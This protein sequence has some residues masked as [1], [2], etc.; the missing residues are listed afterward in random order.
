MSL[1]DA[2]S[3][4][5]ISSGVRAGVSHARTAVSVTVLAVRIELPS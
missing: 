1:T 3:G 5:V 4:Y 2:G